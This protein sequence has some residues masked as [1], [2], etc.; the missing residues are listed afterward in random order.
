MVPGAGD[1]Q[2]ELFGGQAIAHEADVERM[3]RVGCRCHQITRHCRLGARHLEP[4]LNAG[5]RGRTHRPAGLRHQRAAHHIAQ[6]VLDGVGQPRQQRQAQ[7]LRDLRIVAQPRQAHQQPP[8]ARHVVARALFAGLAAQEVLL[9]QQQ[10][11]PAVE[12][13]RH[14]A[15]AQ[16]VETV[17]AEVG[18]QLADQLRDE[19]ARSLRCFAERRSIRRADEARL[20]IAQQARI[21]LRFG[22]HDVGQVVAHQPFGPGCEC[23]VV[24]GQH[25]HA[26]VGA[27]GLLQRAHMAEV[28]VAGFVR[29]EQ[30]ALGPALQARGARPRVQAVVGAQQ[31]CRRCQQDQ[32]LARLGVRQR[33]EAEAPA[34]TADLDAAR[35]RAVGGCSETEDVDSHVECA[36]PLRPQHGVGVFAL[37]LHQHQVGRAQPGIAV[38]RARH[39]EPSDRRLDGAAR[40]EQGPARVGLAVFDRAAHVAL[41]LPLDGGRDAKHQVALVLARRPGLQGHAAAAAAA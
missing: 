38:A 8:V 40:I 14:G 39:T 23:V 19:L 10:R 13:R 18:V 4:E 20:A 31:G 1:A 36:Q 28:P 27:R 12:Q 25:E 15:G 24:E 37:G 3:T 6:F 7:P 33:V 16:P 41:Q 5:A 2:H 17:V 32:A 30:R 35:C 26:G 34:R 22:Q 21:A 29:R 9:A 11:E